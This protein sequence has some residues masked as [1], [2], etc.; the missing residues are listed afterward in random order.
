M[1]QVK[2]GQKPDFFNFRFFMGQTKK[3]TNRNTLVE[4][5]IDCNRFQDQNL[6]FC[7]FTIKKNENNIFEK[8]VKIYRSVNRKIK[9]QTAKL[10]LIILSTRNKSFYKVTEYVLTKLLFLQSVNA[11]FTQFEIIMKK[12]EI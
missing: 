10:L 2:G 11:E 9:K 1:S 4:S 7:K 12:R 8:I 6:W 5:H 3:M